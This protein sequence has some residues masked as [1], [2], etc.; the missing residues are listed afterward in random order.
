MLHDLN[1]THWRSLIFSV[2]WLY[3]TGFNSQVITTPLVR[4]TCSLRKK[5]MLSFCTYF[6]RSPLYFPA[7]YHSAYVAETQARV[8]QL[9]IPCLLPI[10]H[11]FHLLTPCPCH[12]LPSLPETPPVF[13]DCSFLGLE[14]FCVPSLA[15]DSHSCVLN[16]LS[17]SLLLVP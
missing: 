6:W 15:P 11:S 13:L 7:S 8:L 3:V 10:A 14:C 2:I 4:K 16:L 17:L 5:Y 9:S 12:F 1:S